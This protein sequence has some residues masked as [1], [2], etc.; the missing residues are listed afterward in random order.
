M[1]RSLT[2]IRNPKSSEEIK[3]DIIVLLSGVGYKFVTY[4]GEELWMRGSGFWTARQFIRVFFEGDDLKIESWIPVWTWWPGAEAGTSGL[5]SN[6]GFA[7]KGAMRANL[8]NI[9]KIAVKED[10]VVEGYNPLLKSK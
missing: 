2:I 6:H 1:A 7:L 5:E 4:R 9:I 8:G 10:S 3:D